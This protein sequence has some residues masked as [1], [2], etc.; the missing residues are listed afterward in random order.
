MHDALLHG[1]PL[2][3]IAAGDFEDVAFEFRTD[4]V[5]RDFVA[6][7]SL[8]EN[9]EFALVFD[10]D[11]LLG[12]I[13]GV[14]DVEL[15]LDGGGVASRWWVRVVDG[16]VRGVLLCKLGISRRSKCVGAKE[17]ALT[18]F[19]AYRAETPRQDFV[20][21]IPMLPLRPSYSCASLLYVAATVEFY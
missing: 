3:I 20:T 16:F 19:G 13:G 1:K 8:H 2:F 14:G 21:A 4:A 12:A 10:F 5:A 9:A 15:H 17:R 11:E 18:F 7:A 6:H